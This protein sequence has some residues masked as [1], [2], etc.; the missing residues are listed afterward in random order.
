TIRTCASSRARARA[1]WPRAPACASGASASRRRRRRCSPACRR[2]RAARRSPRARGRSCSRF[3]S[4]WSAS[5]AAL[6][7][8]VAL[9]AERDGPL[10]R[11][12]GGED[13]L[14]DRALL[15]PELLLA[16]VGL[17]VEDVL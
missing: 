3:R 13:R 11:V 16:P 10:A 15:A 7:H 12:L 1:S 14:D 17:A 2:S 6:P 8:R 5:S 9:L 4:F